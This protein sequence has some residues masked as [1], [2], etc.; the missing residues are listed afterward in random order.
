MK[1]VIFFSALLILG[2]V[3]I[4]F[5]S[6]RPDEQK[7]PGKDLDLYAVLNLFSKSSTLKDFERSLNDKSDH[8]NNL[9]LNKDGKVDYIRVIDNQDGANHAIILRVPLS[10][11]SSQD[12]AVI[13]TKKTGEKEAHV[14]IVGDEDLYGKDFI[15]EPSSSST[16]AAFGFTSEV[17][18][19][20]WAWP[21]IAFIYAPDYVAWVSPWYWDYYPE[22]WYPWEPVA[23]DVYY[24]VVYVYHENYIRVYDRRLPECDHIYAQYRV[25]TDLDHFNGRKLPAEHNMLKKDPGDHNMLNR[26]L[27][28]GAAGTPKQ[29]AKNYVA[30]SPVKHDVIKPNVKQSPVKTGTTGHAGTTLGKGTNPNAGADKHGNVGTPRGDKLPVPENATTPK[31]NSPKNGRIVPKQTIGKFPIEPGI[32]PV[33]IPKQ[34]KISHS[35]DQSIAP[36]DGRMK[37]GG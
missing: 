13:E 29:K 21:C 19:N 34:D 26:D 31:G 8:V 10:E 12:V 6:R 30:P 17:I 24:P 15:V 11:T 25:R 1:R 16:T 5:V 4:I 18:V 27:A 2:I 14:Q 37:K 32:N 23:W 20:V 9:D 22:W 36:H 33:I 35:S 28:K 7:L 3:A